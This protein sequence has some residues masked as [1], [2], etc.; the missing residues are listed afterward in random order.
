MW[1]RLGG[2]SLRM[3]NLRG[4]E[5]EEKKSKSQLHWEEGGKNGILRRRKG[6]GISKCGFR[7]YQKELL[8][9]RR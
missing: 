6:E 7:L 5:R 4:S 9:G 2:D 3:G 1:G 8:N